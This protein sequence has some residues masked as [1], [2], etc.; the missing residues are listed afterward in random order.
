MT[1]VASVLDTTTARRSTACPP[2]VPAFDHK[3][4]PEL[5]PVDRCAPMIVE[6]PAPVALFATSVPAALKTLSTV[7]V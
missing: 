1:S 6:N 7:E 5:I 2:T 3:A 4:K